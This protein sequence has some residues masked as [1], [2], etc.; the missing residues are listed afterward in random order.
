MCL[1]IP[2]RRMLSANSELNY[3]SY[4]ITQ[5]E[6]TK[7]NGWFV[8]LKPKTYMK[9]QDSS[10]LK[11]G[12]NHHLPPYIYIYDINPCE[13]ISKL[14]NFVN[15]EIEHFDFVT[16]WFLQLWKLIIFSY[17]IQIW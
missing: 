9:S 14:Q 6:Q 11:L 1:L 3:Q 2:H 5:I 16:L 17:D 8:H 13:T 12:K 15:F 10:Q 7:W 4:S